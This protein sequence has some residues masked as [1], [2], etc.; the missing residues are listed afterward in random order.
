MK[1]VGGRGAMLVL[2]DK[3][4]V[5]HIKGSGSMSEGRGGGEACYPKCH[6]SPGVPLRVV[7]GPE[8]QK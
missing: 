1:I 4:L 8:Q 5:P 7:R 2:G 3:I 6:A